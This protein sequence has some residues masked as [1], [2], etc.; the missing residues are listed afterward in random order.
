MTCQGWRE[1]MSAD[2]DGEARDEEIE[3]VRAHLTR[4]AECRRIRETRYPDGLPT[5]EAVI[6]TGSARQPELTGPGLF[7]SPEKTANQ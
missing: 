4:C 7:V 1:W 5:G 6:T 2:L 3:A